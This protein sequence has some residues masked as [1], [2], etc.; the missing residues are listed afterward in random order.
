MAYKIIRVVASLTAITLVVMTSLIDSIVGWGTLPEWVGV[1]ILPLSW[2]YLS[3]V[4]IPHRF[5]VKSQ[6][7]YKTILAVE[8]ASMIPC[9]VFPFFLLL[10]IPP[11][12]SLWLT[13][14]RNK[15][16][17]TNQSSDPT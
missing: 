1:L 16:R 10:M 13:Y 6:V 3:I 12:I 14:D 4:L 15:K 8:I 5:V 7:R 17:I 11:P 2:L 9:F